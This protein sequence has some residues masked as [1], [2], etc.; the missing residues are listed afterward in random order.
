MAQDFTDVLAGHFKLY[1]KPES[2]EILTTVRQATPPVILRQEDQQLQVKQV[3]DL[4]VLGSLI[5][6]SGSIMPAVRYRLGRATACYWKLHKY[7]CEPSLSLTKRL[8]EFSRRVHAAA[9]YACGAWTQSRSLYNEL[10]RWENSL[11]RRVTGYR[12]KPGEDFVTSIKRTTHRSRHIFHQAGNL[13]L[14]TKVLDALHRIAGASFARLCCET[15]LQDG[16]QHNVANYSG[17]VDTVL[18]PTCVVLM[19]SQCFLPACIPWCDNQWWRWR[20][21]VGT[22]LDPTQ[23]ELKWR[24]KQTGARQGWETVFVKVFRHGVEESSC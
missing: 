8:D 7:L 3:Q 11:L 24:H 22:V 14:A 1:W 17:I 16:R 20:Q 9:V 23:T 6:S 12:R 13:S 5:S 18:T 2:L 21:A 10:Y 19:P 15:T 4:H